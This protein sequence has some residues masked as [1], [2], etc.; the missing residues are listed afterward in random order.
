MSKSNFRETSVQLDLPAKLEAAR[1]ELAHVQS[2]AYLDEL[3]GTIGA[4]P[5][6]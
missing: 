2:P 5:L 3:F 1:N 4:D 6:V